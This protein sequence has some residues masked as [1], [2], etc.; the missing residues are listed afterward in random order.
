MPALMC[1]IQTRQYAKY[2]QDKIARNQFYRELSANQGRPI[3]IPNE[4]DERTLEPVTP[5]IGGIAL[6]MEGI[7]A[8][9]HQETVA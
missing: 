1:N 2:L 8:N 6:A 3:G 4:A 7:A 5:A 9:H